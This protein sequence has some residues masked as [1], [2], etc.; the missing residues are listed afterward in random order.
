MPGLS[1]LHFSQDATVHCTIAILQHEWPDSNRSVPQLLPELMCW[2]E[3]MPE[4]FMRADR[5]SIASQG[6]P[7]SIPL[8]SAMLARLRLQSIMKCWLALKIGMGV[9]LAALQDSFLDTP[10]LLTL[11]SLQGSGHEAWGIVRFSQHSRGSW[12]QSYGCSIEARPI[13]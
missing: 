10:T 8:D 3:Q 4:V 9:L 7:Q 6:I 11:D 13:Y 2:H 5:P 1:R 12:L